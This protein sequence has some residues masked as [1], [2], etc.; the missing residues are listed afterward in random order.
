VKTELLL[1]FFLFLAFRK[2]HTMAKIF[3]V[4]ISNPK[5]I[6]FWIFL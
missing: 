4:I 5:V 2:I 6:L 3:K 1:S